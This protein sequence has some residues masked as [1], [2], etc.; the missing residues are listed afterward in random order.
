MAM[1]ISPKPKLIVTI[2]KSMVHMGSTQSTD[3]RIPADDMFTERL[4]IAEK[5]EEEYALSVRRMALFLKEHILPVCIKTNALVLLHDTTC[6]ISLLLGELCHAER[7]KRGGSLPFTVLSI[8]GGKLH[9]VSSFLQT[10]T[11]ITKLLP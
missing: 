9:L 3:S 1:N 7:M 8:I 11:F 4:Y 6:S 10:L 2:M 5:G